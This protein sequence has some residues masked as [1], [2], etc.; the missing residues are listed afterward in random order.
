MSEPREYTRKERFQNWFY[1]NKLYVAAVCVVLWVAG[2]ML[3][4]ALGIGRVKPDY[5]IAYVGTLRLPDACVEALEAELAGLGRDL[6]GDG[7]VTV[8]LTQHI[9]GDTGN[10]ENAMYGYAASVTLLADIT[11]GTSYYFLAEDPQAVMDAFQIFANADGSMP[12]ED[13]Y[14]IDGKVLLWSDCPVLSA[15]ELGDY[16]DSY[17]DR[18]ETGSCQSLLSGLYLGRRFYYDETDVK[19]LDE[20]DAFWQ[21]LTAGAEYGG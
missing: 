6:N 17:L 12:P 13:D 1:Y 8:E 4:N 9:T 11:E 14:S 2:S 21:I 10:S 16:E 15:L 5:R 20:F 19:Y 18:T 3:W 7:R